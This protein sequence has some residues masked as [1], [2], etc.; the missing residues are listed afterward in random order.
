MTQCK[1]ECES[2]FVLIYINMYQLFRIYAALVPQ[3]QEILTINKQLL[4][5]VSIMVISI[6]IY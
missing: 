2:I 5:I 3:Q 4:I 1:H 6:I